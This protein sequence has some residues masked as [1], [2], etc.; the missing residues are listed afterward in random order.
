MKGVFGGAMAGC[1]ARRGEVMQR[2]VARSGA[3]DT[4]RVVDLRNATRYNEALLPFFKRYERTYATLTRTL[5]NSIDDV[6]QLAV[7]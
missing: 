5:V 4:V 6:A 7:K 1:A 3:L 2:M